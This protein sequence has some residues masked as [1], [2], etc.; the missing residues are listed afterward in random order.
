MGR[1][2]AGPGLA[3]GKT[4]NTIGAQGGGGCLICRQRR[5]RAA[6]KDGYRLLWRPGWGPEA[7]AGTALSQCFCYAGIV[8]PAYNWH[9]AVT[10]VSPWALARLV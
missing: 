6:E 2:P 7:S 10:R 5:R 4:T 8:D 3:M 9:C 1:P